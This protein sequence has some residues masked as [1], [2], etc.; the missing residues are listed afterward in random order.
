[1]AQNQERVVTPEMETF[2]SDIQEKQ[3]KGVKFYTKEN[4]QRIAEQL[5]KYKTGDLADDKF[6]VPNLKGEEVEITL[7][8]DEPTVWVDSRCDHGDRRGGPYLYYRS[9][10]AMAEYLDMEPFNLQ[11]AYL[12]IVPLLPRTN[13]HGCCGRKGKKR[14]VINPDPTLSAMEVNQEFNVVRQRWEG[15]DSFARLKTVFKANKPLLTNVTKIVA[16]ACG[17]LATGPGICSF[18]ANQ[19]ALALSLQTLISKAKAT[20]FGFSGVLQTVQKSLKR[21][22]GGHCTPTTVPC[23]AQDPA[24]MTIDKQIL[25]GLGFT[26]VDDPRGFL[27]V[28][29]DSVVIFL[30]PNTPIQQVVFDL[31]RPAAVFQEWLRADVN[32]P[33]AKYCPNPTSARVQKILDNE[34]TIVYSSWRHHLRD[35]EL[36]IRKNLLNKRE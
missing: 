1:M 2:T 29:D 18:S 17:Q 35:G 36:Y 4:I 3:A 15:S 27:E 19:H 7:D 5:D 13:G 11:Q 12:P 10:Q 33:E 21:K 31:A 34:Y 23:F 6:K 16:F 22:K 14:A 20:K 30:T 32:G 25:E 26:I 9:A 24:Y 28:D 8:L